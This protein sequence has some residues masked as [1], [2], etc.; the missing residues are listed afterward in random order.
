MLTN[1]QG[2]GSKKMVSP[3]KEIS[4]RKEQLP[5]FLDLVELDDGFMGRFE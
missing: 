4:Y 2:G 3:E 5:F 1:T